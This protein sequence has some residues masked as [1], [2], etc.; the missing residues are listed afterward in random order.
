VSGSTAELS[1]SCST[2][3]PTAG[4]ESV[5]DSAEEGSTKE[6]ASLEAGAEEGG[7]EEAVFLRFRRLDAGAEDALRCTVP[8]PEEWTT[9]LLLVFFFDV[10]FFSGV[11][12]F[13][14]VDVCGGAEDV[15]E[16]ADVF[17]PVPGVLFVLLPAANAPAGKE[18]IRARTR[19]SAQ[20]RLPSRFMKILRCH[21]PPDGSNTK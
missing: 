13:S 5:S 20:I 21:S 10:V 2:T 7:E 16:G 15:V 9:G 8:P 14:G 18:K 19:K 17:S 12:F 1:G 3:L 4:R 6:A 11:E